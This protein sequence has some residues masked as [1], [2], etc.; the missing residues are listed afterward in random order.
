MIKVGLNRVGA[1]FKQGFCRI[2]MMLKQW[3][4]PRMLQAEKE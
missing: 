1:I 2:V 4:D 3:F